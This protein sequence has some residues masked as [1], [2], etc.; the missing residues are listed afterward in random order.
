YIRPGA[1]RILHAGT[2]DAL[3]TTAFLNPEGKIAVVVMNRTDQAVPFALQYHDRA[4]R[5]I[6]PPHSIMTLR[7][8][9]FSE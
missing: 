6:S 4:A 1:E 3:E 2:T 9:N 5:T 7:F 8:V